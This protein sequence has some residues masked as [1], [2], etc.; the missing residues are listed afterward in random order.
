MIYYCRNELHRHQ[1][2]RIHFEKKLVRAHWKDDQYTIVINDPD[3]LFGSMN[4]LFR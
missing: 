4:N 2:I 1:Y 3:Q